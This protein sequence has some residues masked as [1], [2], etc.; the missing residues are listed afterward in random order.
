MPPCT[1][2]LYVPCAVLYPLTRWCLT[3]E[4]V[5][6]YKGATQPDQA[7][8]GVGALDTCAIVRH[9]KDGLICMAVCRYVGW[10]FGDIL[11]EGR[12]GTCCC[13]AHDCIACS[14]CDEEATQRH[15][16]AGRT[17]IAVH[18]YCCLCSSYSLPTCLLLM[19]MCGCAGSISLASPYSGVLVA[20]I[21]CKAPPIAAEGTCSD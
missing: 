12:T 15:P 18:E 1:C 19:G 6:L 17:S 2:L 21:V 8:A 9:S 14:H 10:D 20:S 16:S 7:Q 4:A 5:R 13:S 11:S 3:D